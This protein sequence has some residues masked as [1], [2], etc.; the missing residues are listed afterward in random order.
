MNYIGALITLGIIPIALLFGWFIR[1]CS[2]Q[3]L[4]KSEVEPDRRKGRRPDER[5][6][7]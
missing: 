1:I 2:K 7:R 3:K 6:A 4:Q 5:D